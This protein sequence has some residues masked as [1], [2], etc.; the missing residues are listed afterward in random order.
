MKEALRFKFSSVSISKFIAKRPPAIPAKKPAAQKETKRTQRIEYPTNSARSGLSR[1]AFAI[2]PTGV[3]VNRY[4]KKVE[5]KTQK[6]IKK[7]TSFW[8]M[9]STP[10][11]GGAIVLSPE[12]PS[13]PPKNTVIIIQHAA[14]NSPIPKLIIAKTVPAFLVEKLPIIVAKPNPTKPPTKGRNGNGNQIS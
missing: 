6:A 10:K 3:C 1:T 14:I 2:L 13:S 11:V 8:L 5:T 12:I 4:I 9:N 7:Y